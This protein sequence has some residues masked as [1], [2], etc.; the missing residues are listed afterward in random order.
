MAELHMDS[1]KLGTR[2]L[3]KDKKEPGEGE[4]EGEKK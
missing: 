2:D 4:G 1:N 3:R